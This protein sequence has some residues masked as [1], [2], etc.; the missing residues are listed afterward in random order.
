MTSKERVLKAINHQ[1]ADRLPVDIGQSAVT[2]ISQIAYR[3]LL[4]LLGKGDRD[5]NI[6]D[7]IQQ[8]AEVDEDILEMFGV[9]MRGIY[10][11]EP[12]EWTL[13]IEDIGE[14]TTFKDVWDVEWRMPK[15]NGFYYDLYK[16]PLRGDNPDDIDNI[17]IL[18]PMDKK[19]VE[20]LLESAKHLHEKNEQFVMIGQCAYTVGYLQQ[21]QWLQGF[22]DSYMNIAGNEVFTMKLLDKLEELEMQ[23]WEWFLPV[24][25]KY[26]D[27]MIMAD[28]YA[29]QISMLIS[30]NH[31]RK[32]FKPRYVRLFN[33]IKKMAP[34]MKI[35]FHSCGA[36]YQIIPDIIEMGA[37][38]LNPLQF[39]AEG[40]DLKA[41][42]KDFGKDI[43]FWGGAVDTQYT[44][45]RGTPQEV[46]DEIKRNL[47][48]LMPG[49]GYVFNTIHDIQADV[50]PE[51][52]VAMWEA[53]KEHGVY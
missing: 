17:K 11:G 33:K 50:P 24:A 41:I 34:H 15:A 22:E 38:V 8:L 6:F 20:P 51:N 14:Y 36:I 27:M 44:L 42:K 31:F 26:I 4:E 23:F 48:I 21:Y 49:G 10:F 46:K 13:N 40:M 52:I 7:V 19:R 37:D 16:H 12:E 9:D 1:E 43:T 3:N 28:D 35:F 53:I 18:D 25:G 2:G 30:P 5:I 32:Y 47:D 45:P 29:G 39:T